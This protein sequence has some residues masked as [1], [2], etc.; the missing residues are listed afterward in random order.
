MALL[1]VAGVSKIE[2]EIFTVKEVYF[3]QE[4]GQKIAIAGETG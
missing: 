1:Q 4:A 3:N 2:K